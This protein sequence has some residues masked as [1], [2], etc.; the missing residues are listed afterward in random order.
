VASHLASL[1]QLKDKAKDLQTTIDQ[2]EPERDSL[3]AKLEESEAVIRDLSTKISTLEEELS[4]FDGL[5]KALE[6]AGEKDQQKL[7][8]M[9]GLFTDFAT[10]DFVDLSKVG[11]V[12]KWF[13]K[14]ILSDLNRFNLDDIKDKVLDAI[15]SRS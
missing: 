13:D 9:M 6:L 2:L 7:R 4:G 14:H 10:S 11:K 15:S 8:E 3:Q 12:R 5:R 1:S